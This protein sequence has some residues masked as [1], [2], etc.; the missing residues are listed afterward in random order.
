MPA[1]A[2]ARIRSERLPPVTAS[3]TDSF[4]ELA[5]TATAATTV[6][7][8]VSAMAVAA[9]RRELRAVQLLEV[10]VVHAWPAYA[11]TTV[12]ARRRMTWGALAR[13]RYLETL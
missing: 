1:P 5:V 4:R 7:P 12:E 2:G 13:S 11:A 3:E 10:S 8:M 9:D 6:R